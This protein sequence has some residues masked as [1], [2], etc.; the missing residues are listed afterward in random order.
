[1]GGQ[2]RS[3]NGFSTSTQNSDAQI[4]LLVFSSV[5]DEVLI[6]AI[7]TPLITCCAVP[8]RSVQRNHCVIDNTTCNFHLKLSNS[9]TRSQLE[10]LHFIMQGRLLADDVVMNS[11]IHF[12]YL[13]LFK[14][15]QGF[16]PSE[17]ESSCL[18]NCFGREEFRS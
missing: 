11:Y 8:F 10:N 14:S 3:W 13:C 6:C 1:M 17:N 7:N 5:A 15:M 4:K 18:Y 12:A 16:E 2:Y 9:Y